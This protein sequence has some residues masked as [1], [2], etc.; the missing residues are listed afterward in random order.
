VFKV[1]VKVKSSMGLLVGA[2]IRLSLFALL[3][4]LRLLVSTNHSK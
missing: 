4:A 3:P 1:I 2:R